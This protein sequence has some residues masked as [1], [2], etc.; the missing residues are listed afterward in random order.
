MVTMIVLMTVGTAVIVFAI[1]NIAGL[2]DGIALTVLGFL[3]LGFFMWLA[4]QHFV[5]LHP[6]EGIVD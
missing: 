6:D 2:L 5:E 1:L 3:G 4:T